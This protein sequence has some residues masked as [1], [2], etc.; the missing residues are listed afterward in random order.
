MKPRSDGAYRAIHDF[1]D[2][3]MA[4]P[5]DFEKRYHGSVLDRQFLHGLVQF[6][7]KLMRESIPISA[8]CVSQRSDDLGRN[9]VI[10]IELLEA[11]E[12]PEPMLPQVGQGGVDRN[13]VQ[14]REERG[15]SLKSV[16]RLKCFDEGV[17]R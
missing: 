11:K 16:N 7:L 13:P 17:L 4:K 5:I 3:L 10:L 2:L 1:G 9:V 6:F 15:L 14:P 8:G 12:R